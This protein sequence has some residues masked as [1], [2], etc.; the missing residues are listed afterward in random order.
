MAGGTVAVASRPPPSSDGTKGGVAT[1]RYMRVLVITDGEPW[2]KAHIVRS[3]VEQGHHVETFVTGPAVGDFYGRSRQLERLA[4]NQ[5][6]LDHARRMIE[7]GGLDLMFCYVYDDF[8]TVEYARRLEALGVP[9]VNYNVD[10]TNQWY[11]QIRTAPYFRLVLC[12]QR[13]NM[14]NLVRYGA[15][16]LYFPMAARTPL[17]SE[18]TE[19]APAAPVTFVG[20]PMD[21][22]IRVLSEI[23]RAGILLAVYGRLWTKQQVSRPERSVQKTASDI[24]HYGWARLRSEGAAGLLRSLAER[25]ASAPGPKP[26][27]PALSR[28]VQSGPVPEA[29]LADV[30]RRSKVNI[31]ITRMIGDDPNRPGINQVK[32]RD[33]E[34]PG[35]GGFHLVEES[36]DHAGLFDIGREIETWRTPAELIDKIRYYLAN[37]T[38]RAAIAEAGRRRVLAEHT[39]AHRFEFLF[40]QLGLA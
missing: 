4:R 22:R 34:V 13:V 16:V 19:F 5:G 18:E 24:Y 15:R 17:P 37:D 8:L 35:A 6:L 3:L 11:R 26:G 32:L 10:M 27:L 23:E 9:I 21:Y 39:W 12:A 25:V 36:K 33:F 31:G 2:S 30:F 1:V 29:A 28:S 38:A 14:E 7:G 20:T 40:R